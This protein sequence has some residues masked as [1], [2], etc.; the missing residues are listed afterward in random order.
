MGNSAV[1]HFGIDQFPDDIDEACVGVVNVID[2]ATKE[3]HG[4][5]FWKYDGTKMPG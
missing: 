3:T 4:G 1:K 2:G 5:R